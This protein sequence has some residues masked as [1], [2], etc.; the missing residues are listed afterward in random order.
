M[1]YFGSIREFTYQRNAELMRA[2]RE[3]ISSCT[4][5]SIPEISEKIVNSPC[6]RFWVSEERATMVC[7][8]IM[9]GKPILNTMR[10][11]KREMFQEIY[12][13]VLSLQ[14][15][16]PDAKLP[17]LVLMVV[18]SPAPKFYMQPRCAMETIYKIKKGYYDRKSRDKQHTQ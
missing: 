10:P 15:V 3:A 7:A 17:D 4:I 5:I 11:M 8:A 12:R 6:A 1:K 13:R 18:N 14:Q 9:Q 16:H 2:Y